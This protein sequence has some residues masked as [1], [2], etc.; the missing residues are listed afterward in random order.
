MLSELLPF[1]PILQGGGGEI[2]SYIPTLYNISGSYGRKVHGGGFFS[3]NVQ[4]YTMKYCIRLGY[5]VCKSEYLR[6]ED[7]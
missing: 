7:I 5:G 2:L 3:P 4:P 6:R 1:N